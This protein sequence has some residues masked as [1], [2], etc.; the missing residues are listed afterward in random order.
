MKKHI[1]LLLWTIFIVATVI[2][3]GKDKSGNANVQCDSLGNCFDS[4]NGMGYNSRYGFGG[5]YGYGGRYGYGGGVRI[6]PNAIL[7]SGRLEYIENHKVWEKVQI[8]LGICSDRY[9][10]GAIDNC[11]QNNPTI[12]ITFDNY[13][14]NGPQGTSSGSF[15]IGPGYNM[16]PGFAVHWRPVNGNTGYD[17]QVTTPLDRSNRLRVLVEGRATDSAV[18]VSLFYGPA[19]I[20][21]GVLYRVNR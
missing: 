7:L 3:C 4:S 16:A 5:G 8:G 6:N 19:V 18:R 13:K 10:F 20:G 9:L 12:S 14:F 1:N 15:I 2:G 21:Q 17:T 11:M